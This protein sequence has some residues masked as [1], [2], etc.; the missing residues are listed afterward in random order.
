M[1]TRKTK[2]KNF[3]KVLNFQSKISEHSQKNLTAISFLCLTHSDKKLTQFDKL[4]QHATFPVGKTLKLNR[5]L[6]QEI[7]HTF[8]WGV[9][10]LFSSANDN[11]HTI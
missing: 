9:Y 7:I 5:L 8:F 10:F 3:L 1:D 6:K 11:K 4:D 2:K